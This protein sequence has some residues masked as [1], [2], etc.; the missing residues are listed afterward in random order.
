MGSSYFLWRIV[1]WGKAAEMCLTGEKVPAD[2]ALRM[3][4]VNHVYPTDELLPKTMAMAERMAERSRM[5]LRI[6]KGAFNMALN[7]IHYEDAVSIE[8]RG[9]AILGLAMSSGIDTTMHK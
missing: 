4:L 2:E 8:D 6:T 9:Q 5:A 7:G 3:G 1:G